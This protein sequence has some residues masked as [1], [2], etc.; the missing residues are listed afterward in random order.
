MLLSLEQK[1]LSTL[2][3]PGYLTFTANST[4]FLYSK[5]D[6]K[7]LRKKEKEKTSLQGSN[8]GLR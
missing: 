4:L 2:L 6:V 8:S 3:I 1:S 5:P 7:S